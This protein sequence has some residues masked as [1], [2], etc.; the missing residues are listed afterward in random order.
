MNAIQQSQS[1]GQGQGRITYWDPEDTEFW[2]QEGKRHALR[3]LWISIPCLLLAFSVWVF[4][5]MIIVNMDKFGFPWSKTELLVLPATAGLWGAIARIPYTFLASMFGGK[6][7][8]V[9]TTAIMIIPCWLAGNALQDP[10]TPLSTFTFYA[11]LSGFGGGAFSASMSNI[12]FFFPKREAGTVLGLNAGLGNLG[13]SVAQFLIPAVI[14]M[15]LF[16]TLGG[17][18]SATVD[19]GKIMYLQNATYVWM[20][21]L[22]LCTL[23]AFIGMDNLQTAKQSFGQMAVIFKRKHTWIMTILYTMTFGSFIGFSFSF[24]QLIKIAF[25]PELAM[26]FA[27]V[28]ALI[29]SLIRPVGGWLSDKFSSAKITLMITAVL[30][31]APLGV[32]YFTAAETANFTGYMV[33]FLVLFAA[34]GI[35]N[36][37]TFKMI[38]SIFPAKEAGPVLGWTAAVAAFGAW[39][40]PNLFKWSIDT[41]GDA[42]LAFYSLMAFYVL[43]FVLCWWYYARKNA[44]IPC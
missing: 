1:Q 11:M 14:F 28:G 15:P 10:T 40:I 20:P 19:G 44:E 29:G 42:S 38:S 25:D 31:V 3:N 34:S 37:S 30:M 32:L 9:F 4:W 12:N 16:G 21:L 43:C 18:A 33:M 6:N 27:F 2:N 7:V 13:V 41:C 5:S 22:A 17:G 8:C 26:Q 36:G 35:G 39:A 23:A 24:P